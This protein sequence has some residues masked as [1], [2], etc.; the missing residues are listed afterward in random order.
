MKQKFTLIELLVVIAIIAILAAMLLPALNKAR[1]KANQTSCLSNL[2]QQ[3]LATAFYVGDN[4]DNLMPTE[5]TVRQVKGSQTRFYRIGDPGPKDYGLGFLV[6]G[7]YIEGTVKG[8]DTLY[9]KRPKTLKCSVQIYE[10][11]GNK[12]GWNQ[13]TNCVDYIY[14]R[15][16][17]SYDGGDADSPKNFRKKFGGLSGRE[18]L[19]TCITAGA[20]FLTSAGN[21]GYGNNVLHDGKSILTARADGSVGTINAK[22][23]AHN[24]RSQRL[25]LADKN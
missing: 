10:A 7:G 11:N 12:T 19:I 6:R 18:S 25:I 3:M 15:D 5:M 8:T 4:D 23:L 17:T 14:C 22:I 24:D 21:G 16:T 20:N 2:K 1:A 9:G 13:D